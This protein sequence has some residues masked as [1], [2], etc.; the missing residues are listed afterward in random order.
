MVKTIALFMD[1]TT[2]EPRKIG[3]FCKTI[4]LDSIN[5]NLFSKN[6][7]TSS[8]LYLV[9]CEVFV[10]KIIYSAKHSKVSKHCITTCLF[11]VRSYL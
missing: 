6:D 9:T 7:I 10:M 4:Y 11:Y 2:T 8:R 3:K 1:V 5:P